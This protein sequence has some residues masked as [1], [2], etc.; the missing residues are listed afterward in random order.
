MIYNLLVSGFAICVYL[1]LH[2]YILY[3]LFLILTTSPSKESNN[4]IFTQEELPELEILIAAYN[5][6]KVIGEKLKTI[7]ESKYPT[8]KIFVHI[9][10][11][12]STD[13]TNSIVEE[14]AAKFPGQI[15]L[16]IFPGRTGKSGIINQ[17]ASES[18]KKILILSDAN[19][20]FSEFCIT[21]MMKH[22]KNEKIKLVAANI[23]KFSPNNEGIAEQEKSYLKMEN[24]IK[25]LESIRW[26]T[27]MGAE[28]GCYAIRK[29]NFSPVPKNFFMDD[30]Y[31]TLNVIENKGLAIFEP[32]S[33]C[34]EDV[35]N[36]GAE[37]FKRKVRISV[38]NFQNLM[39]YKKLLWPFWKG[40][41]F[42][43]L[44]H[45]VLRWLTPFLFL[46]A[47][48]I[49][50]FLCVMET[51]WIWIWLGELFLFLTPFL[52]FIF[53]RANM[54]FPILRYFGHFMHMNFALLK[55]FFVYAR[56]V[57]SNVWTP[58]QRNK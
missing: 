33:I 9:G 8:E 12:A 58:T 40:S 55:G 50:S 52:N 7:F 17:L 5:E 44:S 18:E 36:S 49:L 32:Q 23:I 46:K 13:K 41:G 11:D 21:E 43:F 27:I 28:G 29:E 6:E 2:T 57:N 34:H 14:F 10:S 56:G 54:P 35:P 31:I 15:K 24:R 3:P 37:E 47:F 30:F 20:M 1:V 19:V 22:F 48:L 4:E 25:L 26:K 16:R 38:G 39:R 53:E 45:K 51:T 42:A